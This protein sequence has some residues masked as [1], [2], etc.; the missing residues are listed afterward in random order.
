MSE[1]LMTQNGGNRLTCPKCGNY[2][3]NM[4]REVKDMSNLIYDYPPIYGKKYHC[5]QCGTWWRWI[6]DE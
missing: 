5:G 6:R 1:E 4:I 3:R 2:K